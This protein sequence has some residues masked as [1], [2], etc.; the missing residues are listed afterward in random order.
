MKTP[1]ISD[2]T[3]TA[4]FAERLLREAFPD[5]TFQTLPIEAFADL[6][7]QR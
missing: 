4:T 2:R 1:S 7:Y 5:K 3:H 6:A